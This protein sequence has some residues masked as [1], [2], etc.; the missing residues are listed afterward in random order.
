MSVQRWDMLSNHPWLKSQ[1]ALNS[2]AILFA[3][4]TRQWYNRIRH[5]RGFLM[6]IMAQRHYI[7]MSAA[8]YWCSDN[9]TKVKTFVMSAWYY[10][11]HVDQYLICRFVRERRTQ[12]KHPQ[13]LAWYPF[14]WHYTLYYIYSHGG[15]CGLYCFDAQVEFLC[16]HTK[17]LHLRQASPNL[18]Q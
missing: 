13:L 1:G 14:T 6:I 16:T 17:A 8:C 4:C 2:V 3:V 7:R 12:L 15:A 10:W 9:H 5:Q 18:T 11:W